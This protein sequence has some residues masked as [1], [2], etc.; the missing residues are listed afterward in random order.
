MTFCV[1]HFAAVAAA[2]TNDGTALVRDCAN[3]IHSRT[4]EKDAGGI[5]S[6]SALASSCYQHFVFTPPISRRR[7]VPIAVRGND[8]QT[9]TLIITKL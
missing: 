1:H 8:R 5:E 6:V 2:S 7:A 4:K 9:I 3:A